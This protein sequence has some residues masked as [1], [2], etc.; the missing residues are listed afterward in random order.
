LHLTT[1]QKLQIATLLSRG[2]RF[3]RSLLGRDHT[4]EVIRRGIRW[5]LDLREG[6]DLALYLDM[7][8]IATLA[9]IRRQ[10]SAGWVVLDIGA[11]IGA[12]TLPM[13]NLVGPHGRVVAFE[14][15]DYAF[16]KLQQNISLNPGIADRILPRQALLVAETP[17]HQTATPIH[18]SWP[19]TDA[20]NVH[21][22]HRGRLM[23]T[24]GARVVTLDQSVRELGLERIDFIKLDVDGHEM[25]VLLGAR[26]TLRRF[27]PVLIM[28]FAPYIHDDE[29]GFPALLTLLRDLGYRAE[30]K[31]SRHPVP[32][33]VKGVL[34]YC[35]KRGSVDLILRP[36]D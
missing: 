33:T 15:T 26:E 34:A 9:A 35:S 30:G 25:S 4:A 17:E 12:H 29:E 21:P 7:Y 16:A 2:I 13:A 36:T 20:E 24:D 27:R 8:E 14:P 5:Q 1:K 32:L 31:L 18:S 28:E 19:L 6:I 23:T 22:V 3:G 10:V 11:N